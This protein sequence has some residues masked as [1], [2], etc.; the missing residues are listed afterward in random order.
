MIARVAA[1][2]V[3]A[4]MAILLWT[5]FDLTGYSAIVFSFIGHP[6]MAVGLLLGFLALW[7]RLRREASAGIGED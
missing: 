4:A 3:I 7:R 1:L 5:T 2:M 6:L